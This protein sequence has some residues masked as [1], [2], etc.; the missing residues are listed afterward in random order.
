[1]QVSLTPIQLTANPEHR[2]TDIL[3]PASTTQGQ[4]ASH[5]DPLDSQE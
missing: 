1:V 2:G 3:D 4:S 5:G